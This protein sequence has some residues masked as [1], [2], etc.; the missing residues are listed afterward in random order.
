MKTL[1]VLF[2]LTSALVMADGGSIIAR[3]KSEGLSVTVFASPSPLRAGPA[4]V[5]VLVQ[6][7]KTHEPVPG[8]RVSVVLEDGGV[9]PR[10]GDWAVLCNDL[11]GLGK[12]ANASTQ[13]SVNRWLYSAFLGIPAPGRW[14]LRVEIETP[15]GTRAE[16]VQPIDVEPPAP[17]LL[18]WW[19]FLAVV[20]GGIVLYVWRRHLLA[21]RRVRI[22]R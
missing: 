7:A 13:H 9:N 19:P 2:L 11:N 4:D 8:A 5:S 17:P 14:E 18:A 22:A 20:P 15:A 3:G 12:R 21:G 16:I 1:A 6:D 10:T